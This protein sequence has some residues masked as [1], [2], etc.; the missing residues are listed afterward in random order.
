MDATTE[1]KKPFPLGKLVATPSALEAMQESNQSPLE[2]LGRHGSGDWGDVCGD[3]GRLN[4]M[5]DEY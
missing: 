4:D 1:A 3:D 2:F 5:P